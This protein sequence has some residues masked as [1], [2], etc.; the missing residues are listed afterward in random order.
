MAG[1][2]IF[3]A[4]ALAGCT[5]LLYFLYALRRDERNIRKRTGFELRLLTQ[6]RRPGGNLLRLYVADEISEM[7]ERKRT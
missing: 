3:I 1:L 6:R 7:S 4:I 5:F 2:T